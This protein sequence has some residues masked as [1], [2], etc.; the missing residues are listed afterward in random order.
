MKLCAHIQSIF[1]APSAG[2]SM[3]A[4]PHAKVHVDTGIEGDRYAL[5]IGAFSSTKP[6]KIRHI[7][8]ITQAG[9]STANDW[10]EADNEPT[11]A[12]FETRRNIVL[13]EI[14]TDELN[15]LVGKIFRLGEI[16]LRG[17]ELC[18]PCQ[19]PAQ[20]LGRPSFMDAFDGRGGLRAEILNSGTLVIGD[21]LLLMNGEPNDHLRR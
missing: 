5:K 9:I 21:E 12:D 2:A 3:Q 1:I 14:T 17:T 7:S 8:L 16:L 18:T 4:I 6:T 19:R 10:L 15:A 11:F 13:A 20:L